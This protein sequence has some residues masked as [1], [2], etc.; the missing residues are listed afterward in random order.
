MFVA[1]HAQGKGHNSPI[2]EGARTERG[3]ETAV[4]CRGG[5]LT[6]E[7]CGMAQARPIGW[8]RRTASRLLQ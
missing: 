4:S 1:T 2:A 5:H 3:L 6:F 8:A 7:E